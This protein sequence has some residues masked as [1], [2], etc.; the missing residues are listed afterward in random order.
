MAS[1]YCL[2][3]DILHCYMHDTAGHASTDDLHILGTVVERIAGEIS[4]LGDVYALQFGAFLDGRGGEVLTSFGE[5]D[6]LHILVV[7]D[8]LLIYLLHGEELQIFCT[9]RDVVE[10]LLVTVLAIYDTLM[11]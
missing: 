4:I 9:S 2:C 10:L 8:G 7:L 3:D 1:P 6:N 11:A 5:V